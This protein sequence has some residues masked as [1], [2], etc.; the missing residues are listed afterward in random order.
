MF[1]HLTTMDESKLPT[2]T[3]TFTRA[4]QALELDDESY[5]PPKYPFPVFDDAFFTSV[6]FGKAMRNSNF[7]FGSLTFLSK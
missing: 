4:K 7:A 6:E 3:T 1:S 5:Q 2:A